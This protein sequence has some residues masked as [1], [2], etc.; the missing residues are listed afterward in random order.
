MVSIRRTPHGFHFFGLLPDG[1]KS[2]A[3][4]FLDNIATLLQAKIFPA[5][6][7]KERKLSH[8]FDRRSVHGSKG[9]EEFFERRQIR[10][11][12]QP[13]YLRDIAPGDFCLFGMLK[14]KLEGRTIL[15][16][17]LFVE[18]IDDIW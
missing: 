9:S 4:H 8:H 10:K 13:S 1:A 11:V 15:D 16:N 12:P 17:D 2:N 3:A 5:G 7:K 18:A 14:R 6:G